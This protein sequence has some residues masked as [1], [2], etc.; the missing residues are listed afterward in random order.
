MKQILITGKNS[1]IAKKVVEYLD[2]C[3][4]KEKQYSVTLISV[5]DSLWNQEPFCKYDVVLHCAAL[6]HKKKKSWEEYFAI[7]TRLTEEIAKKAKKE[8]VKQFIFLSTMNVYGIQTGVITNQTIPYPK[9]LYGKSKYMAEKAL[10]QIRS[11]KF[12]VCIL[13]PPMVYGNG[14]QGNYKKL[15]W[16]A[17]ITPIFPKINNKRSMLSIENLCFYIRQVI[18]KRADGIFLSQN[19]CYVNTSELVACIAKEQGH[20]IWVTNKINGIVRFLPKYLIDKI[21]G[22]LIY[23]DGEKIGQVSFKES[24]KRAEGKRWAKDIP[25]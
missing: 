18:E 7:N 19:E 17:K 22:T 15:S 21:F 10:E 11:E 20:S 1:Y 25:Y 6:V 4:N 14:C 5:R 16:F 13:R 9:S 3:N 23:Q 12:Q 24:I 8:G 2:Y